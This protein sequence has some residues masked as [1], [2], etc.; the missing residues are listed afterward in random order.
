MRPSECNIKKSI[1]SFLFPESFFQRPFK[2]DT[3]AFIACAE[4]VIW[5]C[6]WLPVFDSHKF[7]PDKAVAHAM[8]LMRKIQAKNFYFLKRNR[9]TPA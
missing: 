7:C 6:R 2:I 8:Q 4:L 9:H 1:F 5:Y 3:R